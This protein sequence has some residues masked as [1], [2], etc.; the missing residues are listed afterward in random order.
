MIAQ[1]NALYKTLWGIRMAT[2]H[3]TPL[4]SPTHYGQGSLTHGIDR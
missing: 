4:P 1:S 2:A 3:V